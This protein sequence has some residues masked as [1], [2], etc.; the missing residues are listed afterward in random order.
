MMSQARFNATL[1]PMALRSKNL[2]PQQARGILSR[3]SL[4]HNLLVDN[5]NL[6]DITTFGED[7]ITTPTTLTAMEVVSDS[8]EDD[9][10][11]TGAVEMEIHGLDGAWN[12]KTQTVTMD[13]TTPVTTDTSAATIEFLRINHIHVSGTSPTNSQHTAVGNIL[14]RTAGGGTTFGK[15][16]AGSNMELAT[17][18]TVP[19]NYT[20]YIANWNASVGK[21]PNTGDEILL[22]LRATVD[23]T[24]RTPLTNIFTF[25]DIM[26]L[27]ANA[28]QNDIEP[29][30]EFPEKTEIKISAK[31]NG[32]NGTAVVSAAFQYWLVPNMN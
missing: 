13:G 25:Q 15:I 12:E 27:T 28:Q 7:Y 17:R 1:G 23:P 2:K 31:L 11:G 4:G 16:D 5:T 6:Q 3:Y 8:V 32:G 22:L 19:I 24:Q 30:F 26:H 20:A 21:L 29:A 14:L 9:V 18:I 10:G